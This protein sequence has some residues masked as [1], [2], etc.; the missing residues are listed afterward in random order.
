MRWI[1]ER[2]EN[3]KNGEGLERIG[4][5]RK[6]GI[7]ILLIQLVTICNRLSNFYPYALHLFL[8]PAA[9]S[10]RKAVLSCRL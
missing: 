6:I 2:E 5:D 10:L 7:P 1:L 4:R 9:Q 3:G 8:P